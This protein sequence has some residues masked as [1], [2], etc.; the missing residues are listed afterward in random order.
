MTHLS[1][2]DV[3]AILVDFNGDFFV[4]EGIWILLSLNFTVGIYSTWP[5]AFCS[6]P[7]QLCSLYVCVQI[8]FLPSPCAVILFPRYFIVMKS[9]NTYA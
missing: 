5:L 9:L 8:A 3:S 4:F 7:C 1:I 2:L 6:M